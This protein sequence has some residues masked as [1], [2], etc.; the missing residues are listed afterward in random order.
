M[1][2]V[3]QHA[4]HLSKYGKRAVQYS[5]H[6]KTQPHSINFE[7]VLSVYCTQQIV[8]LYFERRISYGNM[9][10]ILTAEAFRVP[11]QTAWD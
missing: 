1:F 6:H 3:T 4:L 10:E 9:T 5:T 11:K 8:Q 2:D 7:M